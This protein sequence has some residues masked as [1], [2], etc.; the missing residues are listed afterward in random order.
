MFKAWRK[1]KILWCDLVETTAMFIRKIS[2]E[3]RNLSY[4][5]RKNI[6]DKCFVIG[7]SIFMSNFK[8]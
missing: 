8:L 3:I 4:T 6:L 1:D 5:I 7:Q 2:Y